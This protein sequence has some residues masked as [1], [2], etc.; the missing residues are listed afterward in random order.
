MNVSRGT[1][2]DFGH[3]KVSVLVEE[4]DLL[5]MLAERGASDPAKVRASMKSRD[6]FLVM[7]EEAQAYLAL[8]AR[9]WTPAK[10]QEDAALVASYKEHR[11]NRND[12]I[13]DAIETETAPAF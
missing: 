12:L 11:K 3:N 13:D 1:S 7:D 2:T 4:T 5:Q 9:T 8:A 6:V 10:S